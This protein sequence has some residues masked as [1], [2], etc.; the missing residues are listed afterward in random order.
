MCYSKLTPSTIKSLPTMHE[1][2]NFR[3]TKMYITQEYTN[4]YS[5]VTIKFFY[6]IAVRKDGIFYVVLQQKQAIFC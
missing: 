6:T 4:A 3:L 1:K 5:C 2:K